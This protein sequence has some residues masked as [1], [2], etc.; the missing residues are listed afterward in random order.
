MPKGRITTKIFKQGLK[1]TTE[2][3]R[4]RGAIYY[5]RIRKRWLLDDRDFALNLHRRKCCRGA[6][7][8][9]GVR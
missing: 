8:H 7:K 5:L 2:L 4:C 6:K 1:P 9:F 3:K